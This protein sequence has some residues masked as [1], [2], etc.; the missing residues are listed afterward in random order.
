MRHGILVALSVLL[1]STL[2]RAN[3]APQYQPLRINGEQV[4]WFPAS[5]GKVILTYAIAD[6]DAITPEAVNC[7][8]MRSPTT[9]MQS[10]R[11]DRERLRSILREAFASWSLIA[12]ISFREINDA[13]SAN[14]LVG[15]QADPLGYAFTNVLRGPRVSEGY[16]EISKAAICFNPERQWKDG[17]GGQNSAYDLLYTLKHEIGHVIGLDHPS[18]RGQLMSFSYTEDLSGPT[19]GDIAGAVATYGAPAARDFVVPASSSAQLIR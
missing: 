15:E 9:V 13:A 14:V 17:R 3:D 8:R 16:R 12:S 11:I 2:A 19:A 6:R 10:A 18:R 5:D 1:A 4:R 7:R